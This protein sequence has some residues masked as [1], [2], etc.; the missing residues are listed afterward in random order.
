[1]DHPNI[2]Y[3]VI[4]ICSAQF[5]LVVVFFCRF[6]GYI[7]QFFSLFFFVSGYILIFSHSFRYIN[8]CSH[9]IAPMV[10]F[11]YTIHS[12]N[13]ISPVL[14]PFFLSFWINKI[15]YDIFLFFSHFLCFLF[16]DLSFFLNK[17]YKKMQFLNSGYNAII[18][19][20]YIYL[21]CCIRLCI[22]CCKRISKIEFLLIF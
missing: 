12:T 10:C 13:D 4:A 16:I 7:F 8:G 3:F 14:C 6:V 17:I 9:Y 15:V 1:M 2:Q 21:L 11:R 22:Y 5:I 19:I 18:F 20:V